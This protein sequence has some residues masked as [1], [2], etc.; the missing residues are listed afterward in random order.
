L[1]TFANRLLLALFLAVKSALKPV[2]LGVNALVLDAAGRVL[3]VRH[4]YMA[5]WQLPGGGVDPGETPAFAVRRE[6]EEEIGLQGG[7]V[8]LLGH[9]ARKVLWMGHV[10]VLYRIDGATVAF[11][12]SLE[13]QEICWADVAAPPP[14]T[15]P[16]T[17]R[18]L[19]E[20]G[21]APVSEVW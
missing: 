3:L 21:G 2:A 15:T 4:G 17:L 10:V 12:P 16:A 14:N 1:S 7:T 6:L 5:G 11:R 8:T 18:R 9:H 20:L 19:A 13:V